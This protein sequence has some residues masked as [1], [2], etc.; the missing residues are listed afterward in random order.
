MEIGLHIKAKHG[1]LLRFR[2]DNGRD[3]R[4]LSQAEAAEIAGVH[5][6]SWLAIE[7]MAFD[8]VSRNAISKVASAIGCSFEDVVPEEFRDRDMR[9]E[10]TGFVQSERMLEYVNQERKRLTAANPADLVE[11]AEINAITCEKIDKVLATLTCRER[12]ILKLRFGIGQPDGMIL[13]LDEV[14]RIFRITKERVRAIEE[15]AIRKLQ[16]PI[17]IKKL[18]CLIEEP[19]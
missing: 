17:R 8:R 13:T 1:L 19:K 18:E 10:K 4:K 6:A 15:R 5:I 9:W 3:G 16:Y 11:Q 14:S 12:E 2:I 7:N